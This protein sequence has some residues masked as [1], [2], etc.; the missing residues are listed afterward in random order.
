MKNRFLKFVLLAFAISVVGCE[1][2][3]DISPSL[4][5]DGE[6]SVNIESSQGK[7][8][9]N[10]KIQNRVQGAEV[11]AASDATWLSDISVEPTSGTISFTAA[12]NYDAERSA[13]INIEYKEAV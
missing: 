4:N 11:T 10:Y 13:I 8:S 12:E 2:D 5:F 6:E 7:Y 1:S 9:I 3:E